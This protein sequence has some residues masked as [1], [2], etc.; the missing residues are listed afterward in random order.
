MLSTT[1]AVSERSLLLIVHVL[2]AAAIPAG[3]WPTDSCGNVATPHRMLSSMLNG[4]PEPLL[5]W[6]EWMPVH[7]HAMPSAMN[8]HGTL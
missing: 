7:C 4:M 2:S 8:L 3:L 6:P 1:D 5:Y